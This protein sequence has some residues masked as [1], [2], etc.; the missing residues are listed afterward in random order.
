MTTIALF[1]S[2]GD[3]EIESLANRLASRG[4]QPWVIELGAL[5]NTTR[6][7]ISSRQLAVNGRCLLDAGA[8]YLRKVTTGLPKHLSYAQSGQA[9]GEQAWSD[10]HRPSLDA[11][12][13]ETKAMS[14]RISLL[15]AFARKRPLLS[16]PSKQNLHRL[17]LLELTMLRRANLPVPAYVAGYD[18]TRLVSWANGPQKQDWPGVVSKPL[19][20][21]YKTKLCDRELLEAHPPRERPLFLQRWIKGHTIRCYVLAGRLLAAAKIVH[22]GTV[23]S[24]ESQTGI[25][26]YSLSETGRNV[27]M[28][29]AA[30]LGLDFCG[31]DLMVDEHSGEVFVIDCNISPMF[32]NFG[33]MSGCDIAGA[34]ADRL[35]ELGSAQKGHREPVQRKAVEQAKNLIA[36]DPD[37][38]AKLRQRFVRSKPSTRIGLFG[39]RHDEHIKQ[40]DHALREQNAEPVI[41]DLRAFPMLTLACFSAREGGRIDDIEQRGKT[42]LNGLQ[43]ALVRTLFFEDFPTEM[44][45]AVSARQVTTHYDEHLARLSFQKSLLLWLSRKVPTINPPHAHRYH[46]LKGLQHGRLMATGIPTPAAVVTSDIELARRFSREHGDLVVA[47]PQAGGAEVVRADDAYFAQN[48]RRIRERPT[49]FQQLVSGRSFRAY[50]LGGEV[51]ASFELFH[52]RK[53]VDWRERTTAAKTC[54][55]EPD[56]IEHIRQATR[57]LQLPYC[58]IDLEYDARSERTYFLDFN[59]SALFVG[60]SRM[61]G[62]NLAKAIASYAL[63]VAR[64]VQDLF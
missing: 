23:D 28:G 42:D 10:L 16:P 41:V 64:G 15:E 9:Y 19:A 62:V 5:D 51:A 49:M 46:M 37:L 32:V 7:S 1:G 11:L 8:A 29:T 2:R 24:S 34:L 31:L 54:E 30:A 58:G 63:R 44:A 35:I 20:G 55:L 21:I 33:A 26:P 56:I 45:S 17:K 13:A 50:V 57:L 6:L 59:P 40:L 52:D 4:A 36:E 14:L 60:A 53:H 47:K 3:Q 39:N 18:K 61:T 22:G 12:I 27:A 25:E 48:Q 43:A 38:A